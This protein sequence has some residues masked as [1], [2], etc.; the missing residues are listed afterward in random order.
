M[1]VWPLS[2]SVQNNDGAGMNIGEDGVD[3]MDIDDVAP[4]ASAPS[5]GSKRERDME[6]DIEPVE[7]PELRKRVKSVGASY[8]SIPSITNQ[9]TASSGR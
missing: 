1:S 8:G 9:L 3:S 5:R 6:T 7:R 4:A 2:Q